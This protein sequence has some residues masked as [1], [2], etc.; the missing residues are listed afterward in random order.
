[1][2][3]G[4][5]RLWLAL[6]GLLLATAVS[7]EPC[8]I[9]FDM[10]SS[11]I[12]AGAIGSR[13]APRAEI[14]FLAPLWAGRGLT[15]TLDPAIAALNE[16]PRRGNLPD[17]CLRV[18]GGFSAWRLAL[19]QDVDSLIPALRRIK[20]ASGVVVLIIPQQQ[21]GAYGY[22]GARQLLGD[23]LQGSHVLDLG[24]GS[25]QLAGEHTSFGAALGQKIWHREL[26][27][28]VMKSAVVPCDLQLL[29]DGQLTAARA[30]L[31]EKL[32]GVAAALPGGATLTAIS[33]PVSR[34][35]WPAVRRLVD[36]GQA[37]QGFRRAELAMAIERLSRLSRAEAA[38]LIGA[39]AR[40]LTYLLSD[41]LLVEGLMSATGSEFLQVAEIDL[42]NLPGLL[43]DDR[44]FGWAGHYDC[45]L[46][47]LPAM[48]LAAFNSD[49]AS[50][51]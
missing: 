6:A 13:A 4:A 1:M 18:G 27:R 40:Y 37:E 15:E 22:A 35:V 34:G 5:A 46:A 16:L 23:R 45:Y 9:A 17:G 29:R 12:R 43:A 31:G 10:G 41:M 48:G 44:A 14:D 50:C 49:P 20:A 8:R 47:R 7:A 28:Q 30:L 39:E 42:T 24:G 51:R 2:R 3:V 25:L 26:C 36:A 21:E 38:V 19:Q 32:K 33:R 11:G